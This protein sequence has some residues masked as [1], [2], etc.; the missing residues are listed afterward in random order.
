MLIQI[1]FKTN[2]GQKLNEITYDI[3]NISTFFYV[4]IKKTFYIV[5]CIIQLTNDVSERFSALSFYNLH[6]QEL[7]IKKIYISLYR[8]T[9]T[10]ECIFLRQSHEN[11]WRFI[12]W[13]FI[14]KLLVEALSWF[15][16]FVE[17]YVLC[18]LRVTR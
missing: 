10:I 18:Y 2:Y 13:N 3:F 17:V 9:R 14:W 16:D 8:N 7:L 6:F 11:V 1:Y 12:L 5:F 4:H 15:I